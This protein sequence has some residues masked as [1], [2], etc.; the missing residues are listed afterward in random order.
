[1]AAMV[2]PGETM[3]LEVLIEEPGTWYVACHLIGHYEQ[4]QIATI[5]VMG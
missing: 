4:G 5:D 1:M 3:D 2:Q